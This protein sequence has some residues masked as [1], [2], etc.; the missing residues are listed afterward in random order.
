MGKRVVLA[1]DLNVS[2]EELD[3][4]NPETLMRK[5]GLTAQEYISMPSRRILNQLLLDG[6]VVEERDKGR[7]DPV[8]W[9]I[10]R[11][12][13]QDRKGMFTCWEQKVNARPSNC[14]A[15]IDY[16]LSSPEMKDW[17]SQCDIQEGLMVYFGF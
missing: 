11:A 15:R 10:C 12:F 3:T 8:L 17:F 2:R 13:H 16:I 14:G 7:E 1:G 6:K 4:A 5:N 9:D